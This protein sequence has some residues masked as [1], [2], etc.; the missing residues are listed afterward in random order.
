VAAPSV[1]DSRDSY[2]AV[3]DRFYPRLFGV[4]ALGLIGWVLFRIFAPFVT[5]ILW[6]VLLAFLLQPV[7][8]RLKHRLRDR[9]GVAAGLLTV[10]AALCVILPAASLGVAFPGQASRLLAQVSEEAKRLGVQRPSDLFRLAPVMS[11]LDWL[12]AHFSVTAA[13]VQLWAA[14]R[15]KQLLQSTA[16]KGGTLVL[17]TLSFLLQLVLT[18]FLLFFFLRDGAAMLDRLDRAIPIPAERRKRLTTQLASVTKAVV[19][20]SLVTSL[21]QGALVAIGFAVVG[22]PSPIVFGAVAAAVSLLPVGGT[23]FVWAPGAV[24]LAAEGRWP[25]A[26]GLALY[27]VLIV[28]TVDNILKPR[29]VS[30][31]A[32]IGT[33]PV[34]FGVLGGLAAF[35]AIGAILG[36]VVI[37]LALVLLSWAGE[38]TRR[39]ETT[40][41]T[42]IASHT[43]GQETTATS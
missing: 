21:V 41:P 3:D 32:E 18:L 10:G 11:A 8:A 12:N 34:F 29:L 35:G 30:G 22:F 37:A 2:R 42:N 19:L 43:T 33:L 15:A 40:V 24:V 16:A 23:A 1:S 25:W 4:A 5:P 14:E 9:A 13:E 28:G 31:H 20:G 38:N 7:N 26:I 6:S 27:G 17:G 39:E 36:P